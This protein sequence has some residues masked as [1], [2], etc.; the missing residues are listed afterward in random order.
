L[1]TTAEALEAVV[2]VL[3]RRGLLTRVELAEVLEK[4]K[5]VRR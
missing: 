2:R 4:M 3:F 5:T 1:P